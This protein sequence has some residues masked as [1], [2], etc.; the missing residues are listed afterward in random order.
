[1]DDA[2]QDLDGVVGMPANRVEGGK[3]ELL[4]FFPGNDDQLCHRELARIAST[5]GTEAPDASK[6]GRRTN[7]LPTHGKRVGVPPPDPA[8]RPCDLQRDVAFVRASLAMPPGPWRAGLTTK[9]IVA[10]L[11]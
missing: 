8:F 3:L 2:V 5:D 11:V 1:G 4:P 7:S 10:E 9:A 6:A